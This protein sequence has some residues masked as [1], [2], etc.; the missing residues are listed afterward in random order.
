MKVGRRIAG[1]TGLAFAGAVAAGWYFAGQVH[2]PSRLA[3]GSNKTDQTPYLI[4]SPG[5]PG[6]TCTPAKATSPRWV[7]TS[8]TAGFRAHE[9]FLNLQLPHEAV[10]RTDEVSGFIDAV[11]RNGQVTIG[12]GCVAVHVSGLASADTLPPPLNVTDRDELVGLLLHAKA[13]PYASFQVAPQSL[14]APGP[15]P[16]DVK[17]R[18]SFELNGVARAAVVSVTWRRESGTVE[19][20]G[21]APIDFR[22]FDVPVPGAQAAQFVEVEPVLTVEFSIAAHA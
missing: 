12:A 1:V 13:H 22:D 4:T 20:V 9:N 16:S 3:L 17:V 6:S 14:P 7:I 21:S 2:T 18:G 5:P 19:A 8:G 10:V 15:I 11:E